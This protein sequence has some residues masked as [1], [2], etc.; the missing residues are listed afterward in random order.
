M[1][2]DICF[3]DTETLGLDPAAP[4]WEFAATRRNTSG[5]ETHYHAFIDHTPEPWIH[6]LPER[7]ANDYRDRFPEPG[8]VDRL[9]VPQAVALIDTATSGAHIVGANPSFD[10]QR[11]AYLF[12]TCGATPAWHYHLLD[13]ENLAV[14]YLAGRAARGDLDA[15][16]A[17]PGLPWKSDRLSHAIEV[18][19]AEFDRHTAGGD[20]AWARAQYDQIMGGAA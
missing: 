12:E 20:V 19:P 3:L 8:S 18:D 17:M 11:L 1:P 5:N 16:L 6:D 13:V 10:T 14:G 15:G 2:A 7:F 4:V 9:S